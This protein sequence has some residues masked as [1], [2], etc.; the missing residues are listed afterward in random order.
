MAEFFQGLDLSP[1]SPDSILPTLHSQLCRLLPAGP[2]P[3]EE[4]GTKA[5]FSLSDDVEEGSWSAS[6]LD[7]QDNVLSLQLC[8]PANAPV[9]QYRLSLEASTGYQGS[10]FM[11]G[12]FI[13]LF[14]AW[15][16]GELFSI[17][18]VWG[19]SRTNRWGVNECWVGQPQNKDSFDIPVYRQ[20]SQVTPPVPKDALLVWGPVSFYS[21]RKQVSESI[22]LVSHK[23]VKNMADNS[24]D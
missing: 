16:P 13:L 17:H 8:T 2:V 24:G 20:R 1:G 15:C 5:R 10:S 7:Q 4:A 23:L 14:N 18:W 11:L 22:C 12:H 21:T 19:A 3:S 6:V 9:G